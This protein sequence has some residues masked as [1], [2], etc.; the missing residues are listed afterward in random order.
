MLGL[1]CEFLIQEVWVLSGE[2]EFLTSSQIAAVGGGPGRFTLRLIALESKYSKYGSQTSS[3]GTTQK[4]IRNQA[5][6]HFMNQ[7]L[8]YTTIPKWFTSHEFLRCVDLG[9][10]SNLQFYAHIGITWEAFRPH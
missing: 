6:C 3:M 8:L 9:Y 7:D 4:L 5:P 1:T 10:N 2:P